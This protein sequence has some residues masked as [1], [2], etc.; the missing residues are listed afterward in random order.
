MRRR[1]KWLPASVLVLAFLMAGLPSLPLKAADELKIRNHIFVDGIELSGLTEAEAKAKLEAREDSLKEVGLTLTS[2]YG[3]VETTLGDLGYYGDVETAVRQAIGYGNTGSI[4]K[5]YKERNAKTE[6]YDIEINRSVSDERIT[7]VVNGALSKVFD[8]SANAKLVKKSEKEVSVI[9][10]N[11]SVRLDA[12]TCE[13]RIEGALATSWDHT[14]LTVPLSI[15]DDKDGE[16]TKEL[17]YIT[18]LLGTYTTEFGLSDTGRNQNIARA[19]ELMNGKIVYPGEEVSTYYTIDPVEESNGYALAGVYV[20]NEVVQGVGGGVCQMSTTLYNALL[21]A[22]VEIVKRDY[23]GLPVNYVPLSYD[24]TMAGGYLDLIF[25]NN[26]EHP[27]YI[28]I[29]CNTDEGYITVNV[30]GHEYRDP[31]RTISFDNNIV[32]KVEIPEEVQYEDDPE[33]APGTEE[34]VTNGKTGYKTEL[35]KYVYYDGELQD[36]ILINRSD[37]SMVPKK[38]KRGPVQATT[39]TKA[40]ETTEKT[41]TSETETE[42]KGKKK[43]K[44][45][46][47]TEKKAKKKTEEQTEEQTE[48]KAGKKTEQKTE[49]DTEKKTEQKTEK[50]TEE[51]TEKKTEKATEEEGPEVPEEGPEMPEVE[52]P[53]IP[54]EETP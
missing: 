34:V 21:W 20:H 33:M 11:D 16:G 5:R 52:D 39:A 36:S 43:D 31:K 24:A 35:W 10:G 44:T 22:E 23:H 29:D 45:E 48:K 17:S 51:Q 42:K 8:G 19:A 37:Y 15:V 38:I 28:D 54:E 12:E 13:Q 3:D 40:S 6:K 7:T 2:E 1:K 4:L 32:E 41:E 25:R 49:K 30:Y 27:I 53:I 14:A 26:L 9:P 18:D 47:L 50:K 46:E